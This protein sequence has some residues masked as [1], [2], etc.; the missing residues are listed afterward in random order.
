MAK[1]STPINLFTQQANGQVLLSWD[2]S[3]GSVSYSVQ[4]STDGTTYTVIASPT[5]PKYLDTAVILGTQYF[6]Q[7]A[8]TNGDGTSPYTAAQSVV[9]SPT[10]ELSLGELRTRSQ[11]RADR[12]NSQFVTLPEWNYFINQAMFELYDLLVTTYEDYFIAAPATFTVTGN[13]FLYPLP[14][15]SN[16]FL[17]QNNNS[18]IAPPFLKLVGVDLALN[19]S[20]NGYV[21]VNKFN[22]SDRN[23]F[24]YPNSASTIYGVFNLQYRLMGTNIEFIP[25]PSAGQ[26]IRIWYIPRLN[27]LLADNNLTTIGFSG[28]LQYVIV[29]AAKYALDKEESDTSKLDQE[30]A[31]L[32][33]RIEASAMNR[34]AGNP[35]KIS[36]VRTANSN[37]VNGGWEGFKGGW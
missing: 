28:W 8:A 31:F 32:I 4:R 10:A 9:P 37:G 34:D 7:V 23:R 20:A 19:T 33:K 22:F 15:G 16:S 6:Y 17:D 24:V 1:P 13:Q 5:E 35:D 30:L 2:V 11:Q 26:K 29:R 25:T 27:E 21:T 12:L 18:Y 3:A 14:D 36:D